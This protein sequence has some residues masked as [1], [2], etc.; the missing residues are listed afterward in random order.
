[1]HFHPNVKILFYDLETTGLDPDKHEVWQIVGRLLRT[2]G[3]GTELA[4][5]DSFEAL[6]RP[7]HPETMEEVAAQMNGLTVEGFADPKYL[8]PDRVVRDFKAFLSRHVDRYNPNDKL[9]LAGFN[10]VKFDNPFLERLLKAHDEEFVKFWGSFFHYASFDV[11][12]FAATTFALFAP[13]EKHPTEK[14]KFGKPRVSFR[15]AAV[16]EKF[17]VENPKPHDA[18]ADTDAT[19]AC[20]REIWRT[21]GKKAAQA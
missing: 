15:L 11:Y 14:D 20:F 21:F 4:L 8:P 17:K 5:V 10:I 6:V 19:I 13:P 16:C 12:Q 9:L 1:M 3:E 7:L 18:A 2:T